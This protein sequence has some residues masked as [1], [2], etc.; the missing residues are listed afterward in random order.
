MARKRRITQQPPIN[1]GNNSALG[2]LATL[3]RLQTKFS[4]IQCRQPRACADLTVFCNHYRHK[5]HVSNKANTSGQYLTLAEYS[6]LNNSEAIARAIAAA[7]P[8]ASD[9]VVIF[10]IDPL[11][12]DQQPLSFTQWPT[13]S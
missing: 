8:S 12:A 1:N 7:Q 6:D 10:A 2:F 4:V 13:V 3:I 11:F 5:Q 9:N